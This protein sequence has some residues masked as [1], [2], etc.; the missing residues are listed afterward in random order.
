[1]QLDTGQVLR[2]RIA[3]GSQQDAPKRVLLW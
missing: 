1:V 3:F 2:N